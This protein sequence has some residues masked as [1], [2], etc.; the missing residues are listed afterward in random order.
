MKRLKLPPW[1]VLLLPAIIILSAVVLIPLV[2][3]LYS[4]FTSYR[5]TRPD[6]IFNWVGLFN[7]EKAVTDVKFW[8]AFGRT[9]L[10][11]AVALNLEML[12]GL[13]LALMVSKVTSGQRLLRTMMMFPM[14]FSPILVGFQFK[15]IF[16]DNV[17]LV[18]N[19]LQS[20]GITDQAIPWLVDGNLAMFSII[21]A[22]VWTATSVFGILILAG[23]YAIPRDPLEAA[24][25]DGCTSLQSFRYVTLPF[26]MP[27]IYIAMAIRS[28]DVA[29][30]YDI[31]QIMTNGGPARRTELLWTLIGRTG[32][33][34][35]RMGYA[36]A[37]GY[38]SIFLAI[39]FTVYFFKKLT[40]S[41]RELG[42]GA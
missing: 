37:M 26:L 14:M 6:S 7:Y 19:A 15:F 38:I 8:A 30:A 5:L 25:V 2:F 33:V 20:L 23:L 17:G 22:E 10:L 36:N 31:V 11:L 21:F 41:R 9:V 40:Q 35:A 3:S 42:M 34:D 4:S 32:Y 12:L 13:G 18:N 29:R 16:N 27:F 28:L 24:K 1:L 39:F